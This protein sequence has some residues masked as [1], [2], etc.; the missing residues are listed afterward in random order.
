MLLFCVYKTN[1]SICLFVSIYLSVIIINHYLSFLYLPISYLPTY[2]SVFVFACASLCV[3]PAYRSLQRPGEGI[4]SHGTRVT[5]EASMW[6][7][8]TESSASSASVEH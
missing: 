1:V 5:D 7:L 3:E 4:Q 8:G 6:V 2:R